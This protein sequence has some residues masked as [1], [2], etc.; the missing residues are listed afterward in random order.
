[1][2]IPGLKLQVE[3][4]RAPLPVFRGSVD[5]QQWQQA[6]RMIGN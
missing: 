1:M 6:A 5:A 3:P 4:V 2:Q